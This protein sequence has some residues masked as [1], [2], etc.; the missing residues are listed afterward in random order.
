M[1]TLRSIVQKYVDKLS[2]LESAVRAL[3]EESRRLSLIKKNVDDRRVYKL[4][5]NKLSAFG[6]ED[7]EDLPGTIEECP[8]K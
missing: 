6:F 3:R 7:I 4:D 2:I 1:R 8:L 5:L